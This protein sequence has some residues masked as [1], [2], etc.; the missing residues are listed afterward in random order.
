MKQD[1]ERRPSIAAVP[2]KAPLPW[3][4]ASSD[5]GLGCRSITMN[6]G[7]SQLTEVAFL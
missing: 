4:L 2:K 3:D 5:H 1:W 7:R 6:E